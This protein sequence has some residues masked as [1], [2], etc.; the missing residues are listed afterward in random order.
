MNMIQPFIF[1]LKYNMSRP[2][3]ELRYINSPTNFGRRQTLVDVEGI[4]GFDGVSFI[5]L[6]RTGMVCFKE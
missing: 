1:K 4:K 2:H 5:R 3:A 6:V